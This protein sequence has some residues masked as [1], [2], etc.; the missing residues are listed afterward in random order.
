MDGSTDAGNIEQELV[1]LLYC[2]KD[3]TAEK[4]RSHARFCS[5]AS[6]E[7]A[8]AAGL[9]K[10]LFQSLSPSLGIVDFHDQGNVL[11]TADQ[12]K[13]V[14]IG[15]GTDGA[16]VNIA[17][18]NG[19][20]GIL[21]TACPWIVWAWC[22]SHRLELACKDAFKSKL[23]HNIQEMLLRLFYIY[24]KSPK[25]TREL[26]EIVVDLKE[27]FDLPSGGSIPLRS[28]GSRWKN[29]KRKALQRVID[30][31]G[32]YIN[33]LSTLAED[34]SVKA[35]DRARIKGWLRKWMEYKTIL[36]CAVYVD[37]LKAPSLLSLSL[38]GNELDT[39]C[40]IKHILK[41]IAS[42]KSLAKQDPLLWPTV[43]MV[44]ARIKDE[45]GDEKS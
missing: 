41:S 26:Q 10:C 27:V 30:R 37:I 29:H 24:E 20:K 15:G 3:D 8:N 40:G 43:K 17:E 11:A 5:V 34:R 22:Y 1:V 38:Q 25:K 45:D 16:S 13:P 39:V 23:F 31:Y 35:E 32:A 12:G 4:I 19:V 42:L 2:K 9:I 14:I 21:Q 44:L 6:P 33:H 28:Q 7:K 36:G 18:Q